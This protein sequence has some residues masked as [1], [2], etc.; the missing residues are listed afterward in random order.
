MPADENILINILSGNNIIASSYAPVNSS[1][2]LV[3]GISEGEYSVS[4][5]AS[6][7]QFQKF[8]REVNIKKGEITDLGTID[9]N[10]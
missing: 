5:E 8:I 1:K 6:E 4:L 10:E 7:G 3:P 9:M 2:F